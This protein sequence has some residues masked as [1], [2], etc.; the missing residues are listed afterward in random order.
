MDRFSVNFFLFEKNMSLNP[1]KLPKNHFKT[2]FF[3][4][5]F[6]VGG[7]SSAMIV[8]IW[9]AQT[10]NLSGRAIRQLSGYLNNRILSFSIFNG[11]LDSSSGFYI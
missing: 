1:L 8:V 2:N 5:Q 7:P 4:L 6:L 3:F 11:G 9:E 10:S